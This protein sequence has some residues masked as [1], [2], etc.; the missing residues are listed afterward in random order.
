MSSPQSS[1]KTKKLVKFLLYFPTQIRKYF[2]FEGVT[3]PSV[4]LFRCITILV[5]MNTCDLFSGLDVIFTSKME[6][7]ESTSWTLLK[8]LSSMDMVL[9][10]A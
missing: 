2:G 1:M 5:G 9:F 7:V 3:F 10:A 8:E 6:E 4:L